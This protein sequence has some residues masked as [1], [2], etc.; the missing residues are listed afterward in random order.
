MTVY[1]AEEFTPDE[2]DILRRY[3][4]NLDGPVFALVNLPEVVKGAL[5]ARYSRSSE[6]PAAPVP[7]RVRRRARHQR[8]HHHRRHRRPPPGRGALR[9]GVLRVRRRLGGPARRRPPGLRAGVEPA[10]Q[11]ARVGPAHVVPRA[12]HP[13]HRLRRPHRRPLPLL[14]RPE[15]ARL[16]ARH[17]LRRRDGPAVRHLRRAA[18][19]RC[20]TSSASSSRRTPATPTSS[21]AR[22][23]GPRRSTRCGASCRPRR[24]RTS[25]STAPAR[26]TRQLLLRMRSHPLPEA[27][28]YADLMLRELRKVIPS[29]LKRV[30]LADRGVAWSDY[31]AANRDG[32]GGLAEQ[33]FPPDDRRPTPRPRVTLID[34][35]PDAEVHLV[36]AMLYPHTHVARGADRRPGAG[37]ERRGAPGRRAG[38]RGGAG[39]PAPQ[40]GPGPR[41]DRLPVRRARRL[42]RLPRPPAPPHAHHRVAAAQ[43]PPRL[44]PAR[45]GRPGR[46]GRP[47][48]TR[49]WSAR[50][51]STTCSSTA[52]RPRRPTPCAWPT[53]CAS[54]CR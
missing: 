17:P 2:A 44:H 34:F 14:P 8:R 42:R 48:S 50:R 18:P 4:T 29:F 30:D 53:R 24:C 22:R 10:D 16:A 13:L 1:V 31:L 35:D 40:A 47:P 33:L 49:P 6:E 23:S 52:S 5:F 12:V 3:F 51:R 32:H 26:A 37:H 7:R 28:T 36:T 38:L 21:T 19:D 20:R 41:A 46:R 25:A 9:P 54:P 15:A 45:G 11:G 43:P 27:R 39:Q